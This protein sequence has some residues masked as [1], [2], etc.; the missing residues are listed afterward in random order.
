MATF[1]VSLMSPCHAILLQGCKKSQH[2]WKCT[3]DFQQAFL[4]VSYS[5][6]FFS[7]LF[8]NAYVS[9]YTTVLLTKLSLKTSSGRNAHVLKMKSNN[10]CV[11]CYI[12][13]SQY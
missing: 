1:K 10:A 12:S 3:G 13:I 11:I 5:I 7:V 9:D 4:N 2:C 6:F 8:C